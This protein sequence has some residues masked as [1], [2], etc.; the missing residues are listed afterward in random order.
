[1]RI[2]IARDFSD[3]PIGRDRADGDFTGEAFRE[4]WLI[5]K[6]RKASARDPLI[7]VLDGA[8]GYPSSFL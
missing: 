2:S 6:L 7:V 1:M 4:D 8:E 5:P 3:V